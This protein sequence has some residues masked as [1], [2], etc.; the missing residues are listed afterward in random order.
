MLNILFNALSFIIFSQLLGTGLAFKM[1][2]SLIRR[3][4][5]KRFSNQVHGSSIHKVLTPV[6]D[7]AFVKVKE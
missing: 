4:E 7:N 3:T 6:S 5:N 1:S 2:P